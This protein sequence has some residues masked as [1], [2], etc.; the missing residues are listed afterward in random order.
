MGTESSE[1]ELVSLLYIFGIL[2]AVAYV[3]CWRLKINRVVIYI[4]IAI[5]FLWIINRVVLIE[6]N[7]IVRDVV[8]G[9]SIAIAIGIV[10]IMM[11][12][13]VAVV[14]LCICI[15]VVK[16]IFYLL[17]HTLI[18]FVAVNALWCAGESHDNDISC[19][20]INKLDKWYQWFVTITVW[21]IK[22]FVIFRRTCFPNQSA[23]TSLQQN[24]TETVSVLREDDEEDQD[25]DLI[26]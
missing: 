13:I 4:Q 25:D 1:E 14:E 24:F 22:I 2:E 10:L 8:L 12:C 3:L 23:S 18:C 6:T 11:I 16:I 20:D 5:I 15:P 21:L 7:Q 17:C 19:L 26:N 9:V